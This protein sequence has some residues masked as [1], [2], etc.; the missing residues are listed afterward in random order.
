MSAL[1]T[2]NFKGNSIDN[3]DGEIKLINSTLTRN[4]EVLDLYDFSVRT[5]TESNKPVL[6]LRTDFVDADIRGYYNFALL[7]TLVKSAMAKLMPSKFS[8]PIRSN[9]LNKNNCS[10]YINFKNTDNINKFFR[11]GVLLADKS[12]ISG[13]IV[14]D[15]VVSINGRSKLLNVKNNVITDLSFDAD[16]RSSELSINLFSPSITIL[17]QSELKD[18]TVRLNSKPDDFV[19]SVDWDNKLEIINRGNI[20]AHGSIS[21]DKQRK[22]AIMAIEIDSTD[23]FINDNQWKVSNSSMIIDSSAI[24]I[25]NLLVRNVDRFYQVDGS[26]SEDPNDTLRLEFKGIDID[27]LNFI[28][29]RKNAAATDKIAL[30]LR[31]ILNGKISVTNVHRDML[32][33][34]NLLLNNFSIFGGNYG[35]ITIGSVWDKINKVAKINVMNDLKGITMFNASGSYEPRRKKVDITVN[36]KRLPIAFLNPLLKVFASDVRGLASGRVMLIGETNNIWLQG[37]LF[38]EDASMKINYLQTR[39]I[40]NDS[41]RFNKKVYGILY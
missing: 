27:P 2:S 24:N 30:N 3:L 11:T 20:V 28:G 33:E 25:N 29:K 21:K 32:V 34:G 19:F 12:F 6:S 14:A 16:F 5:F 8:A 41:I 38:A 36:T 23:I 37:S 26:V 35:N 4:N 31:G 17:N 15:S 40:L 39:Y 18:F 1:V 7:G 9:E 22:N 13:T 10:F